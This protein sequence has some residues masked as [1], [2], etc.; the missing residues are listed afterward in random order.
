MGKG[1][2]STKVNNF[3]SFRTLEDVLKRV[4][5]CSIN[6]ESDVPITLED[7]GTVQFFGSGRKVYEYKTPYEEY[8]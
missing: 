8:G 7:D 2:L 4:R 6:L 5:E 3:T 1:F